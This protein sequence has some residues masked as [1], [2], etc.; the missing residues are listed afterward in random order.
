MV[1]Y[2]AQ[3]GK[4]ITVTAQGVSSKSVT[5]GTWSA[6]TYLF[7]IVVNE[8]DGKSCDLIPNCPCPC[9]PGGHTSVLQIAVPSFALPNRYDAKFVATDASGATISCL[10]FKFDIA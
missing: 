5:G 3:P 9:A 8:Q 6:K 4:N 10:T 1:P 2:P 7:G